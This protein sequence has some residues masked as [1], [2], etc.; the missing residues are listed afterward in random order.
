MRRP[1]AWHGIA[2]YIAE[3]FCELVDVLIFFIG[4]AAH[5]DPVKCGHNRTVNVGKGILRNRN[6]YYSG[7][8]FY[9]VLCG[10]N[11]RECPPFRPF[12]R[13]RELRRGE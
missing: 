9:R 8:G 2:G 3:G 13:P 4:K 6:E 1:G 12:E 10:R 7:Y 5:I 11:V